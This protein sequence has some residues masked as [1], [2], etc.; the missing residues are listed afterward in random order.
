MTDDI[1]YLLSVTFCA[2]EDHAAL[3]L[4]TDV[5]GGALEPPRAGQ[6]GIGAQNL[7]WE[8][9]IGG[10]SAQG[11]RSTW[12]ERARAP[13]ISE[14]ACQISQSDQS[15]GD[16]GGSWQATA[17]VG[18]SATVGQEARSVFDST[19][20]RQHLYSKCKKNNFPL[21]FRRLPLHHFGTPN[22]GALGGHFSH[23]VF[24]E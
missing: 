9:E 3:P 14:S 7:A 12:R 6:R 22:A 10:A 2:R 15:R 16:L 20:L 13:S 23:I 24:L 11:P 21:S 5:R 17:L 18:S 4:K 8:S 1:W 19:I